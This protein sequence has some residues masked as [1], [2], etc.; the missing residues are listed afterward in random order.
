MGKEKR[1]KK[2]KMQPKKYLGLM[3]CKKKEQRK[4][5]MKMTEKNI[6]LNYK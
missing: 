5:K 4:N 6:T 1:N 3:R 2:N